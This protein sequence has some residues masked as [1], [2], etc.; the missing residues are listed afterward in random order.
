MQYL[1]SYQKKEIKFRIFSPILF[2]WSKTNKQKINKDMPIEKEM[3]SNP[4]M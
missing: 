1:K 3:T 2:F 4:S